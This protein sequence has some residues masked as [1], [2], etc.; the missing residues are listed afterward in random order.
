MPLPY[1]FL[2]LIGSRAFHH[3]P[4]QTF[5]LDMTDFCSKKTEDLS[6]DTPQMQP[7]LF[8][9]LRQDHR[10]TINPQRRITVFNSG[11]SPM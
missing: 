1:D 9:S 2:F 7:L 4:K 6:P 8:N 3:A 10:V 11:Q 5:L